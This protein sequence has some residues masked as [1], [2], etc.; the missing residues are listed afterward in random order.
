MITGLWKQ[1]RLAIPGLVHR[2]TV[3]CS[4]PVRAEYDEPQLDISVFHHDA[5]EAKAK[6]SGEPGKSECRDE[7]NHDDDDDDDLPQWFVL[8]R[9]GQK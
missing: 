7:W 3:I 6:S 8:N 1:E 9:L 4:T 2:G 5:G